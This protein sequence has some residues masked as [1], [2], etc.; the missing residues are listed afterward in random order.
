[1][2]LKHILLITAMIG[3]F[4]QVA[5]ARYVPKARNVGVS[6]AT[7]GQ[8]LSDTDTTVQ[9]CMDKLDN[10]S[11]G[12]TPSAS[13]VT[14]GTFD[15]DVKITSGNIVAA[16]TASASTFL[17]GDGTWGAGG[18][19][20][21]S[22]DG[23]YIAF[24]T[25]TNATN[26]A[27]NDVEISNI[28]GSTSAIQ[29][30]L[31]EVAK[32]TTALQ[33]EIDALPTTVE[34]AASTT[35]AVVGLATSVEVAE[36]TTSAVVG[37][38][39]DLEVAVATSSIRAVDISGGTLDPTVVI[40]TGNIAA[41]GTASASTFLKGDGSWGAPAGGGDMTAAT[42]GVNIA[43]STSTN[44]TN[45]A[46]NAAQL[47]VVATSSTTMQAEIDTNDVEIAAIHGSTEAIQ[48]QLL[49]VAVSSTATQVEVDANSAQLLEV[50]KSTTA[51]QALIDDL[52][53]KVEVAASTTAAVVGYATSVEVATSTTAAVVGYA[54]SVEVAAST[55][56]AVANFEKIS[57]DRTYAIFGGTE[58]V[59]TTATRISPFFTQAITISTM[60]F[61]T[62]GGTFG[63]GMIEMRHYTDMTTGTD[64]W[65]SDLTST[66][67]W[68]G[69]AADDFTVPA[70]NA[71]YYVPT[72]WSGA[73][74][75]VEFRGYALYD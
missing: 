48:Q 67:N 29:T 54:T 5:F 49:Q 3:I 37:Y 55:A 42:D 6:T 25:S 61:C 17:R 2:K 1:M 63:S 24:S 15:N 8:N 40:T 68:I 21:K 70:G 12:G 44:A 23:V 71:L 46:A 60:S 66:G 57:L 41:S 27:S 39:T 33:I 26:I 53:T 4:S 13:D 32:S 31:L 28:H 20:S 34:V 62:I 51:V 38:A 36:S 7:F 52:P 56:A 19:M 35:S 18:D 50:A 73:V 64:I 22:T 65:A 69:A 14:A 9:S 16:G 72:D 58:T 59:T 75:F 47:L 11:T 45:I 43:F 74:T 10:L 30:Q